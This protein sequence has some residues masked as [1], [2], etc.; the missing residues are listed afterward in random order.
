MVYLQGN[1]LKS[2]TEYHNSVMVGRFFG[3]S[4]HEIAG[5]DMHTRIKICGL[6]QRQDVDDAVSAGADALGFVFYPPSSRYV[7]ETQAAVL[8]RRVPPFVSKVALFMDAS[9]AEVASVIQRVDI[10]L[11]QFHG[12][13][14]EAFCKQFSLPYIK[15]VP[16]GSTIDFNAYCERY[17]SANGFLLDSNAIGQA[18]GSGHVFDWQRMPSESQKSLIL[19][20]GLGVDNVAEAVRQVRP[21][22]VD[23]SSGVEREKGRKDSELMQQ[24]CRAVRHASCTD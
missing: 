2:S 9:E 21:Y 24:F 14:T 4:T 22:A 23:V 16:M 17:S 11:L 19:A 13:E 1:S 12:E 15:S 10:D 20:G 5:V 8:A 3:V 6:T 18:G 7:S